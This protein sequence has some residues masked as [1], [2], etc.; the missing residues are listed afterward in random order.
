MNYHSHPLC[1]DHLQPQHVV[2]TCV[3]ATILKLSEAFQG[4][5]IIINSVLKKALN[6]IKMTLFTGLG[7]VLWL[8]YFQLSISWPFHS[9]FLHTCMLWYYWSL[10]NSYIK[11]SDFTHKIFC[12]KCWVKY[13]LLFKG[14]KYSPSKDDLSS[15]HLYFSDE[16]ELLPQNWN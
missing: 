6:F 14:Q 3:N 12:F 2:A 5:S 8:L 10:K 4:I 7:V 16:V 15:I 9:F 13:T 1:L 11:C